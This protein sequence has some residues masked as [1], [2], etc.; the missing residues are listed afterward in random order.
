MSL[1]VFLCEAKDLPNRSTEMVLLNNVFFHRSWECLYKFFERVPPREIALLFLFKTKIEN[2]Q[3]GEGSR[4]F[5][6]PQVPPS[7][8]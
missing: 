2:K 5:P 3:R 7:Y 1:S 6:Q 4:I 8:L